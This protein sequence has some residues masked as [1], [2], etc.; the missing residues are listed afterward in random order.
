VRSTRTPSPGSLRP[1]FVVGAPF[2]GVNLLAWSLGQHPGLS[3]RLEDAHTDELLSAIE[4]VHQVVSA[5]VWDGVVVPVSTAMGGVA[6]VDLDRDAFL[7]LLGQ[8]VGGSVSAGGRPLLASPALSEHVLVLS[9]LFPDG[10]FVHVV[11]DVDSAV[12][13]AVGAGPDGHSP[14]PRAVSRNWLRKARSCIEAERIL[15]SAVVSRVYRDDLVD[16]PRA[17]VRRILRRM[18]ERYVGQCLW[19]VSLLQG[20]PAPPA[21]TAGQ[22]RSIDPTARAFSEHLDEVR[23][24]AYRGN[25]SGRRRAVSAALRENASRTIVARRLPLHSRVRR[26]VSA[27][28]AGSIVVVVSKGDDD[29]VAFPDREG[30]HFPRTPAGEYT[31]HHPADSNEAIRRLRD[32]RKQGADYFVVPEPSMWWLDHYR[33]FRDHLNRYAVVHRDDAC[34]IFSL[35][36]RA[37]RARPAEGG[38]R[39][40]A[41]ASS[42]TAARRDD[43]EPTEHAMSEAFAITDRTPPLVLHQQL[44]GTLW[45]ITAY[46]NPAG[47]TNKSVNYRRFREG[48]RSVGVPLLTVE[49]AFEDQRF[50]LHRTDADMIVQLRGRDVL[51]QKERILNL[52]LRHLPDECDK[53]AW[54]DADILIPN[55]GWA[56]ETAKLLNDYRVVQPFSHCVRLPPGRS[57][58][59]P[60]SLVFGDGE[61]RLFYG[62]AFGVYARGHRSLS[63]HFQHGHPGY[64]WAARRWLLEKH[65]LFD[66]NL[67]GNGDTDIAQA[68]FGNFDYW[69]LRKLGPRVR[70]KLK[71][72]AEGVAHDVQGSVSFVPGLLVHLW[73]GNL[74]DRLYHQALTVLS[75]FD[76]ERD[77]MADPVTGLYE[78][79]EASTELREWSRGYFAARNEEAPARVGHP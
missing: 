77:V 34:V 10:T 52:G 1:V 55:R 38:R 53:V 46:Y 75:D 72:W 49:V 29:L 12:A 54:L 4:T 36:T 33:G 56:T 62:L 57:T 3:G 71:R 40:K 7:G 13:A 61:N 23:S 17:A 24:R 11:R 16:D 43:R 30:W 70:A 78:W 42:T 51:W 44:P 45:A 41:S 64:A 26:S 50:E 74:K 47:Y 79:A 15:G 67:L 19:P 25:P 9:R 66:G 27:L 60:G 8:A 63:N 39:P 14:A 65:G 69:S 6:P 22:R 76:P 2:S 20:A 58:C 31:G 32:L 18:G 35:R 37:P 59:D 21:L 28:P 73:H 5:S 48:L 68:M